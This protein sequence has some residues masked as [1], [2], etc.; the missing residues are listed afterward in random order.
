VLQT[1]KSQAEATEKVAFHGQ[2]AGA[3]SC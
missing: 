1:E 2:Q 3:H